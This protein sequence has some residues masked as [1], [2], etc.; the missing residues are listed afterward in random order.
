MG[1]VKLLSELIL[2]KFP[3][4]FRRAFDRAPNQSAADDYPPETWVRDGTSSIEV[5]F[6]KETRLVDGEF[7]TA[8]SS[9]D[10]RSKSPGNLFQHSDGCG[11][12]QLVPHGGSLQA[13]NQLTEQAAMP[14]PNLEA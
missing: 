11:E 1:H 8:G 4:E 12:W 10:S 2:E 6:T 13:V 9:G 7:W 3:E 5:L 14:G